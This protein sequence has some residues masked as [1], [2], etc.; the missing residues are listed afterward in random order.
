[1]HSLAQRHRTSAGK[2][3]VKSSAGVKMQFSTRYV[4]VPLLVNLTGR[5]TS[6]DVGWCI[7]RKTVLR[8]EE[9]PVKKVFFATLV[10]AAAPAISMAATINFAG[11]SDGTLFTTQNFGDG[12]MFAGAEIAQCCI[13]DGS[14]SLD[15]AVFPPPADDGGSK[16]GVNVATNFSSG[17]LTFGFT[18]TVNSFSAAFTYEDGLTIT[19]YNSAHVVIGTVDGICGPGGSGGANYVGSGCGA[20]NEVLSL[21]VA[22]ISSITIAGGLSKTF[23]FDDVNFPGAVNPGSPGSVPEPVTIAMMLGGLGCLAAFGSRRRPAARQSK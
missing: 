8:P 3:P 17:S 6:D 11:F 15:N 16:D 4:P 20:P 18:T 9:N 14:G 21:S 10:L 23:T 12:V 7:F 19:A 2:R 22:G 1:M 13:S 5:Q